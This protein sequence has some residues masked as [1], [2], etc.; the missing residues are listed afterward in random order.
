MAPSAFNAA[1]T[2]CTHA[3]DIIDV[4]TKDGRGSLA[5]CYCQGQ[6][7]TTGSSTRRG[8]L[9]VLAVAGLPLHL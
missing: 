3:S 7:G 9:H 1:Y 6:N 4:S 8:K 5:F 2:C